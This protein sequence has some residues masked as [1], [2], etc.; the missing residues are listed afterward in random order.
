MV[1]RYTD[2][3][4]V[5]PDTGILISLAHGNLLDVLLNFADEVHIVLTDVVE[6]E[7]TRKVEMFD[8]DRIRTFLEFNKERIRIEPTGFHSLL[9]MAKKDGNIPLPE[10]IGELS[11]YGCINNIR[12]AQKQIATLVLFEDGWFARNQYTRPSMT[13]LV[14]LT[15]F[16]KY[17]EQVIPGFSF[18]DAISKIRHT[19]PGVSLVH[20]DSAG[21]NLLTES[22]TAWKPKFGKH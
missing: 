8:A 14:S 20:I 9:E 12:N 19:R 17:A 15:A 16:L 5:I 21:E 13:H 3:Q 2:I 4:V 22:K 7:S 18:D 1:K 6:F 10:D 11:I